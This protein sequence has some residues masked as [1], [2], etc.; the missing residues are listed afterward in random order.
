MR[1]VVI[2]MYPNSE[3]WKNKVLTMG[4]DQVLAIYTR[5]INQK[6]KK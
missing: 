4:S 5:H 2:Q 6:D 3:R 1:D